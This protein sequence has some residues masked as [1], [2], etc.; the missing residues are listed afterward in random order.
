MKFHKNKVLTTVSAIA[1]VLAVGAC[2]SSGDDEMMMT[3]AATNG[4]DAATNGG[5][6]ATNGGDAATN[7]GDDTKTPAQ[8]LAAAQADY[9]ALPDD[10]TDDVRA[11][12]MTAL[13]AALML[14][15]NEA[16]YVAYLEKKSLTRH[17]R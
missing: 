9:D 14:E 8:T 11:A 13:V 4:G 5:D 2:S 3:D 17:K 10:A 6:A 12:A 7:G 16:E 15:G 1:L